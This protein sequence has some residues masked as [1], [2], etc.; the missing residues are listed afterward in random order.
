MEIP[1]NFPRVRSLIII[2]GYSL[3]KDLFSK[4]C[5]FPPG[6]RYDAKMALQHPWI[7]GIGGKD[8]VPLTRKQKL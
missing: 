6:E 1:C 2:L 8:D 7:T 4:L 3:A 5:A